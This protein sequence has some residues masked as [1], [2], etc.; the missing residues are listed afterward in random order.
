MLLLSWLFSALVLGLS[1]I[2]QPGKAFDWEEPWASGPALWNHV[3]SEQR[4]V[5]Y[6]KSAE[7]PIRASMFCSVTKNYVFA[8]MGWRILMQGLS[9]KGLYTAVQ[10]VLVARWGVCGVSS[11]CGRLVRCNIVLVTC[12]S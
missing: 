5:D 11:G 7:I 10:D 8:P 3:P 6:R 4:S 12:A 9:R 2:L 1:C